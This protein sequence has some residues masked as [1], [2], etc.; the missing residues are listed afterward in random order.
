M[1]SSLGSF[2]VIFG[3]FF[4]IIFILTG[5]YMSNFHNHLIDMPDG[6]RMLYRSA[7]IYI[8][9]SAFANIVYGYKRTIDFSIHINK[10]ISLILI[11]APIMFLIAFFTEPNYE[12]FER[13]FTRVGAYSI[14]FISVVLALKSFFKRKY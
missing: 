6:P 8:L 3:F 11:T 12:N 2:H 9:L 10:L 4:I 13:P 5:Q 14:L 7:H 1:K